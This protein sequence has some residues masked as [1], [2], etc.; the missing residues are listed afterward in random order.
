MVGRANPCRRGFAA[1]AGLESG[2]LLPPYP[3]DA[4][5]ESGFYVLSPIIEEVIVA[6]DED[7]NFM[8]PGWGFSNMPPVAGGEAYWICTERE[9]TLNYPAEGED[10]RIIRITNYEYEKRT[11][12]NMSV[13]VLLGA[14]PSIPPAGAGG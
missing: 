11:D 5:A 12:R 8:A 6:K 7:G 9:V 2:G 3:L 1:G 13:L 4:S 14:P 10:W